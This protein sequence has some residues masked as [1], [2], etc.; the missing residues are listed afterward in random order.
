MARISKRRKNKVTK[1]EDD[2][3]QGNFGCDP[4]SCFGFLTYPGSGKK[5]NAHEGR[6]DK[7]GN[8]ARRDDAKNDGDARPDGGDAKRHGWHD[9][10]RRHAG[11]GKND[12]PVF[13]NDG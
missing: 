6:G 1:K 4:W 7:G 8:D 9:E 10:G 11:Y 12:G 3:E 2:N 13:R 5:G